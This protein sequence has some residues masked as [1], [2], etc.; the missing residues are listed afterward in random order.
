MTI[1]KGRDDVIL[2]YFLCDFGQA[3]YPCDYT[4]YTTNT[5]VGTPRLYLTQVAGLSAFAHIG[6]HFGHRRK[7][8][9]WDE[10]KHVTEI[11]DI[12]E[13]DAGHLSMK[14]VAQARKLS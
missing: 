12:I 2:W 10:Y 9:P 14:P 6:T 1:F 5:L 7:S 3:K 4:T 13:Y 11:V 8:L